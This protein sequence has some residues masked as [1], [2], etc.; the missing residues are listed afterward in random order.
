MSFSLHIWSHL[1][2]KQKHWRWTDIV[3]FTDPSTAATAVSTQSS[4]QAVH[5]LHSTQR[6]LDQP[7][8]QKHGEQ[9]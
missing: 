2:P 4:Q 5:H 3:P 7:H 8:R 1:T 6:N 9:S